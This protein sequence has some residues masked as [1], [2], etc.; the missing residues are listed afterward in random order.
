LSTATEREHR[1]VML[2]A[3][4]DQGNGNGIGTEHDLARRV[5]ELERQISEVSTP[6]QMPGGN[7]RGHNQTSSA[8]SRLGRVR[9]TVAREIT[10]ISD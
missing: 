5:D 7:G 2:P 1:L 3:L 10:R 9:E 6:V 4:F 8:P